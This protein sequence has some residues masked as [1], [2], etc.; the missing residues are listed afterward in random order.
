MDQNVLLK[1]QSEVEQDRAAL[2]EAVGRMSDLERTLMFEAMSMKFTLAKETNDYI[3]LI[4]NR[5][6]MTML[7][8]LI[9]SIKQES[10]L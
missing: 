1:A 10:G 4:T 9:I 5:L 7:T 8:E 2:R 3:S 6:A